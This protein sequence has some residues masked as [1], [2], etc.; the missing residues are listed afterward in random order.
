MKDGKY[1][2]WDDGKC[3]L[4]GARIFETSTFSV[5]ISEVEK[6]DRENYSDSDYINRCT[7]KKCCNHKWH[8]VADE[9]FLDY[10][11]HNGMG[12]D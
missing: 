12:G 5:P 6:K 7:N 9:E 1:E 10:Y 2:G 4:C 8:P 11:L 3:K